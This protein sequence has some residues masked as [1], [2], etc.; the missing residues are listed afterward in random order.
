MVKGDST[1]QESRA[2]Q[3]LPEIISTEEIS[4]I[5][6]LVPSAG[7]QENNPATLDCL[8]PHQKHIMDR[9]EG[10]RRNKER[11]LSALRDL[12]EGAK[13]GELPNK[14]LMSKMIASYD[15][16]TAQEEQYVQLIQKIVSL[17][18]NAAEDVEHGSERN[19]K[20]S[21]VSSDSNTEGFVKHGIIVKNGI[22]SSN[23]KSS[24]EAVDIDFEEMNNE[25]SKL[26]V[27]TGKAVAVSAVNDKLLETLQL[28]HEKKAA[29]EELHRRKRETQKDIANEA[30]QQ[31]EMARLK[32]ASE[33]EQVERK[34]KTL[35]RL[36]R[37]AR[38]RGIR[39]GPGSASEPDIIVEPQPEPKSVTE[40][41]LRAK[42]QAK[43]KQNTELEGDIGPPIPN[44]LAPA[45]R[46]PR[47]LESEPD[48][49][50]KQQQKEKSTT[51][52]M[53][54]GSSGVVGKKKKKGRKGREE[55]EQQ[56]ARKQSDTIN[57]S[58]REKLAA[59]TARKE[60][61][62]EIRAQLVQPVA[63]SSPDMDE[64][65]RSALQQLKSITEMRKQLE[66]LREKGD[67]LPKETAR[68]LERQ[69][70]A[71]ENATKQS[72]ASNP[73]I[74]Q[75][76]DIPFE[77]SSEA[78]E[79][80]RNS[81]FKVIAQKSRSDT[82]IDMSGNVIRD[83]LSVGYRLTTEDSQRLK[84]IEQA[85]QEQRHLL[86][87]IALQSHQ[88]PVEENRDVRIAIIKTC[89]PVNPL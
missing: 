34:R 85:L 49:L 18:E 44:D 14:E 10:I 82:G 35:E 7:T 22:G 60:R 3:Q 39:L 52:E 17:H 75:D 21:T 20:K 70:E 76:S 47:I 19:G 42:L 77:E 80:V 78:M 15:A 43:K 59:I 68:L 71:E 23:N 58:I 55:Q 9:L 28:H 72:E 32:V 6:V 13:E 31:V 67:D 45:E 40:A 54:G 56:L 65:F 36:R 74:K 26:G 41:K 2:E 57:S 48:K 87:T 83:D 38:R 29:L 81:F 12:K 5:S 89:I 61:M 46:I 66:L 37:E 64:T 84:N 4:Q 73:V 30:L 27:L 24:D 88:V 50:E 86:E 25:L 53:N 69:L 16:L 63:P 1:I 62:R 79:A 11:I 33:Q 51:R 8:T